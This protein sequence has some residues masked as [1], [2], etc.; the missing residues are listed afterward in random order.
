MSEEIQKEAT[1]PRPEEAR[2][3]GVDGPK[4]DPKLPPYPKTVVA[5][6]ALQL[7]FGVLVLLVGLLLLWEGL[8]GDYS[9]LGDISCRGLFLDCAVVFL[10]FV[11]GAMG[12]FTVTHAIAFARALSNREVMWGFFFTGHAFKTDTRPVGRLLCF[13]GLLIL[14]ATLLSYLHGGGFFLVLAGTVFL[15]R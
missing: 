14:A 13:E 6:G 3:E 5:A 9:V 8:F 1:F 10:V 12:A 4:Q 2:Q 11:V 15:G 7:V